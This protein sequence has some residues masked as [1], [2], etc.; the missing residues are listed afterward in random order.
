MP[1]LLDGTPAR[2]MM[3]QN[4]AVR[5]KDSY[6][7]ESAPNVSQVKIHVHN[8]A[9]QPRPLP[10]PCM[11]LQATLNLSV[12]PRGAPGTKEAQKVPQAQSARLSSH[13]ATWKERWE[14]MG[15]TCSAALNSQKGMS[16]R[17]LN[18]VKSGSFMVCCSVSHPTSASGSLTSILRRHGPGCQ[19]HDDGLHWHMPLECLLRQTLLVA[20]AA[21]GLLRPGSRFSTEC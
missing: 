2:G 12:I 1:W 15:D 14:G 3:S 9:V 13:A 17:S 21:S 18:L 5:L 7:V 16:A 19:P 11:R 20:R 10:A 6:P 4:F 8:C